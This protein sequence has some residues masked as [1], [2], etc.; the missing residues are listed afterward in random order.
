MESEKGRT[1]VSTL[2]NQLSVSFVGGTCAGRTGLVISKKSTI[3]GRGEDC[4]I[5]LEGETVSRRHCTITQWGGIYVL[6][7]SSRNG[8]YVNGARISEATLS[9]N[10][11]VRVGQNLL[12]VNIVPRNST[13]VL[14][15]QETT[16]LGSE[17]VIE[18]RPHIIVKGLEAGTTQPFSEERITIGRRP[19]NHLV[20]DADNISR[21]HAAVERRDGQYF[22][23]DLGSANGTYHN[24][25][26]VE[27]APLQHGDRLRIGSFILQVTIREQDCLLSFVSKTLKE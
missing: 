20:L 15:S 17:F 9:D 11:Q 3:I 27:S 12:V 25:Q 6:Q 5:I 14:K 23:V 26:R 24:D 2:A 22:I 10:D 13:T 18:M 4:D 21:E 16:P 7:D 1:T 19:G 8:T